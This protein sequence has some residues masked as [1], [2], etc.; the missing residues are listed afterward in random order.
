MRHRILATEHEYAAEPIKG[1]RFYAVVAPASDEPSAMRALRAVE[2]RFPDVS[3]VCWAWRLRNGDSR[4][5]DAAEPRGSAG[6][7]IL[8]QLEGHDVVDLIAIVL[9]W[10]GGTP[11]GV[12]GLMR[13]YGGAAGRALDRA[14]IVEVAQQVVCTLR[15][16]YDDTNAVHAALAE[17]GAAI[18]GTDYDAQ[19][20]M[21]VSVPA[22]VEAQ[23][24][25]Q[26]RDRTAGRVGLVR[27]D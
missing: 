11:L 14:T 24:A 15:F 23:L 6:R 13:A 22:E 27:A 10:Y 20:T 2:A 3:H 8:Q 1:S 12:G 25:P 26:L 7:P 16:A 4:V 17:F 19:V 18:D 5:W 9:R 21:R